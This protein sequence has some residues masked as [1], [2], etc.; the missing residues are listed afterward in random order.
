M[1]KSINTNNNANRSTFRGSCIISY[2]VFPPSKD[3]IHQRKFNV[4]SISGNKYIV[5]V[6][7]FVSCTC[8]YYYFRG[9]RCKHIDFIMNNILREN[10]PRLYYNNKVLEHLFRFLPGN[11]PHSHFISNY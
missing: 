2:E 8:P 10:F 7:N 3:N 4:S 6:N 11:I 9:K 5:T 1:V